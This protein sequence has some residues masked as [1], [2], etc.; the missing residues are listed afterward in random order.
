MS[1]YVVQMKG[2]VKSYGRNEVL[3][4]VDFLLEKGSIHALLGENGTGKTTL[5]NI[6]TGSSRKQREITVDQRVMQVDGT[7]VEQASEI[8]FIHQEL[9]LINDLNV[10]ENLFLGCEI[11]KQGKL[12]KKAMYEKSKEILE[13]MDINWIQRPWYLI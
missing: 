2:I 10:F 4:G 13:L 1:D 5:M 6:L 9:A 3:H 12:Q 11:K 7:A 8:A